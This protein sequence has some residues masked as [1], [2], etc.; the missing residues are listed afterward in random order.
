MSRQHLPENASEQVGTE[1]FDS[2][3]FDIDDNESRKETS[4]WTIGWVTPT[5]IAL[6]YVVG[7]HRTKVLIILASGY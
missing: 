1:T 2:L 4:K 3:Q 6:F 7:M 5:L